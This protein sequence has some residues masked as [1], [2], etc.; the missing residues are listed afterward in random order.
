MTA[1]VPAP[2]L[3]GLTLVVGLGVTGLSCVRALTRLGAELA[4]VDS[5]PRPPGLEALERDFPAVPR[6]LGGFDPDLFG[7]ARRLLVSPGVAVSTPVIAQ[8]AARGVEVLG[9]IELFAR[10]CRAPV[11][12]I[13]G[14]NGKSTVTTLLGAM[15]GAAGRRT[16]VGGNLG[17]A[18]LDLLDDDLD[19]Y[20]L[21]LSSFQLE[22]TSSLNARVATVL[23]LSPD[24]LDRYPDLDAYAA[25]KARVFRGDGVMVLN[26]DDPRVVAMAEPGRQALRFTL[27]RPAGPGDFGLLE[28]NGRIWLARGDDPWL[29]ADAVPVSGAH[30]QAN[31]LAA[32]AMGQALGLERTAMLAALYAF[33]GLPH[34]TQLVAERDG[35]RWYD[36]SKGTNVGATVAA[37]E[38]LPGPLVVILGGDGKGQDFGALGEPL[39]RKARAVVLI[40]RDAP[41]LEAAL[42]GA[43]PVRHAP[44]M[45][46]AVVQAARLARPGDS[47]LLSP[48]CASF[49]MFSNYMERGRVFAAAVRRVTG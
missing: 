19:L 11:A 30:N 42:A 45:E 12:A 22:T 48:A 15:A 9:D 4:V 43:V 23:N 41:R 44:D 31:A 32:L 1:T 35:V 46:Q 27:G 21:E 18:A 26:G 28:R 39:A 14:S 37:V 33:E 40:G 36:D 2:D 5:R 10:L 7:A 17:N 8:A 49:D 6:R 13:T 24:H 29:P 25:A 3:N 38:G 20:V 16:A 34:R 47:V